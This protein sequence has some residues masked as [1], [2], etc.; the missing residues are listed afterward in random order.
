MVRARDRLEPGARG[1]TTSSCAAPA[2]ATP[3]TR[4]RRCASAI[5]APSSGSCVGADTL[6]RPR[7]LARAGAAV[8]A[9]E[10]RGRHAARLCSAAARAPARARWRAPSATDPGGRP[11]CTRSGTS[12]APFRSRRSRSRR[13]E[14][15]RRVAA[16]ESIRYL[17]PDEVRRVHRE[18]P[19]VLP[20]PPGERGRLTTTRTLAMATG[21]CDRRQE[22]RGGAR[23]RSARGLRLRGLLR[24]RDGQLAIA[25]CARS[26][27]RRSTR[28]LRAAR[29][30][31]A[32]RASPSARW[33]LVDLGR[34]RGARLPG[35]GARLLR[36]RAAVGRRRGARRRARGRGRFMK[37]RGPVVL[38][39][40]DGFG[41]GDGGPGD[42]TALAR[43]PFFA[44]AARAPS[45]A[46]RSRRRARRSACPTGRWATPRSATPRSARAASSTWT[47]CASPR[48][49]TPASSRHCPRSAGAAA[50]AAARGR[51][52]PPDGPRLRR[53]RAQLARAPVRDPA[54]ARDQR[55]IRPILHAFT[56]GRDT[57][58]RCARDLRRAARGALPRARRL[59]RDGLGPLLRDGPRQALGAGRARVPRDRARARA[60][61]ARARWRRSSARWPAT[62]ATS[63]SRRR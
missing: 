48:R 26:P 35:G 39:V 25:T 52:A 29:S 32:S 54:P 7:V 36:A 18:A 50:A 44:E 15:R 22:G 6:A 56:D 27:T 10:F 46:R 49:S 40:L 62:R 34:R 59:H 63:S 58:P 61:R 13:P 19:P 31:S 1:L 37:L 30:R 53:R 9:R 17:V 57:A 3:S 51:G 11:A 55:R 23:A 24:A 2:R 47:S 20:T 41:L 38:V 42:A 33:V 21:D 28:P 43:A 45:A 4:S 5:P 14:I 60:V 8:R 12:C 16:G